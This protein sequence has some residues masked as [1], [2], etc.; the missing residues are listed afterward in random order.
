MPFKIGKFVYLAKVTVSLIIIKVIV[1][2]LRVSFSN[3]E[4]FVLI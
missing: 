2:A 1:I 4:E 3:K